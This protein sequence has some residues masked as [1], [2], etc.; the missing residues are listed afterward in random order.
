[1][2]NKTDFTLVISKII[3]YLG[4]SRNDFAKTLG[5]SRSQSIYDIASG[6][7]RPS[8]DFFERF[9]KSEFQNIFNP[10]WMFTGEG[11]MLKQAYLT[12]DD[13]IHKVHESEVS[14]CKGI[15]LVDENNTKFFLDNIN[16][17][18]F[19]EVLPIFEAPFL[20]EDK[21]IIFE[22]TDTS[23]EPDIKKGNYAVATNIDLSNETFE[24]KNSKYVIALNNQIIF[25][26]IHKKDNTTASLSFTNTFT[27]TPQPIKIGDI[28]KAWSIK[29][30]LA[31]V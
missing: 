16:K 22:L 23:L 29:M 12:E 14:Y 9:F 30:V 28:R 21:T 17:N 25:G 11:E 13:V 1:M 8:F 27:I 7:S 26:T 2:N 15:P 31:H 6:K 3:E 18:T 10:N 20:K 4:V 24:N 19:Q 5:Y